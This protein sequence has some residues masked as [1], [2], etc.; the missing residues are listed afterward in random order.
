V[1]VHSVGINSQSFGEE[2]EIVPPH[3]SASRK[4]KAEI[5]ANNICVV[6]NFTSELTSKEH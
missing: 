5:N 6:M 2:S 4:V 1:S 3:F